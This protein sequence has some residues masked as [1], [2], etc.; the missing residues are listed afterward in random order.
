MEPSRVRSTCVLPKRGRFARLAL[1]ALALVAADPEPAEQA[2]LGA[3]QKRYDAIHDLR[4]RFVQTSSGAA[5]GESSVSRGTVVV[6]RPGRMRWNY[7]PPDGRVIVLD[8]EEIRQYD[9]AEKQ[10]QIAPL[11]EGGLSPTALS[12]LMG[13]GRLRDEFEARIAPVPEGADPSRLGLELVPRG[14]QSFESLVLWLDRKTLELRE[15]VLVDLLG[16]RTRL[17][18]S[19][20]VY[21]SGVPPDAF[22]IDVPEG[23]DEIDL[24]P[25]R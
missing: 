25:R 15:S 3:L 24:R 7:D 9:P 4:A 17:E 6:E 18:L 19:D 16:N 11:K 21:D 22:R 5:L 23:T 2:A 20:V 1:A 10:L 14:D 8:G 13:G 12:F